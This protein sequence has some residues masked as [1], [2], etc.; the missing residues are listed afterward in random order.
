MFYYCIAVSA[1][2]PDEPKPGWSVVMAWAG[3]M[4]FGGLAILFDW[5]WKKRAEKLE[6]GKFNKNI[7]RTE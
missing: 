7:E 5:F 1:V 2:K 4:F 6:L 3:A